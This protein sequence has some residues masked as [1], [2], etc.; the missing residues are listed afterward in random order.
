M[1][2]C[3]VSQSNLIGIETLNMREVIAPQLSLNRTLLELK[4][5]EALALWF[6]LNALNRTLLELKLDINL[7]VLLVLASQSNLIGIE[8]THANL[9]AL[10]EISS[11]SNL[12]GIETHNLLKV[13]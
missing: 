3:L 4:Q 12:I 5:E 11:Q 9:S 10:N 7:I 6:D 2:V 8:T 13:N 1:N